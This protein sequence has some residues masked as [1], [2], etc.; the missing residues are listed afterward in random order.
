MFKIGKENYHIVI[1]FLGIKLKFKNTKK[2]FKDFQKTQLLLKRMQIPTIYLANLSTKQKIWYLSD[3]FYREVGYFPDFKN[4]KTFNEKI[5]WMKFNYYNPQEEK[6]IDKYEF[7]N[8]IKN[9]LKKDYTVPLIDVYEDVNEINFDKLPQKFVIKSTISGGSSG[10]EIIKDKNKTDINKLKYKFNN[11]LQEWHSIYYYSFCRGY[12]NIKP[13]IIIEEYI[14]QNNHQ[15]YDYKFFC[16]NGEIKIIE[17]I[18]NRKNGNFCASFYDE[19]W[20]KLN[21]YSSNHKTGKSAKPKNFEKMKEIAKIL[22][23]DFPFVRVDMY[24]INGK[25]YIGEMTFTP[26][27]GFMKF[28][29]LVWD[30]KLGEYWKLEKIEPK[31]IKIL[32]EFL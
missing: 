20:K 25:I 7:K 18:S 23:N 27:S 29:P 28:N 31:F 26:L 17:F 19:N 16:F 1:N 14:E 21:L 3:K 8:Y 9:K 2:I 10:V 32:N 15:L 5:N 30:N 24:N 11:L 12:K 22:S 4:P 13:R 6:I